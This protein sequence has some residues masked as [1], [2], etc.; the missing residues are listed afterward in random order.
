MEKLKAE[1]RI[2]WYKN[3]SG[4]I[5]WCFEFG[6]TLRIDFNDYLAIAPSYMKQDTYIEI[7]L[8]EF[9][10]DVILPIINSITGGE[11]T[12]VSNTAIELTEK[13]KTAT[14]CARI[15]IAVR[16]ALEKEAKEKGVTLSDIVREKLLGSTAA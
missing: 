1:G 4:T 6:G 7:L 3:V 5:K 8:Q 9:I 12:S 11:V 16:E 10:D 15:P 14:V 2:R 13:S